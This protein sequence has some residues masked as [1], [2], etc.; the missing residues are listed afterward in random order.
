MQD[1]QQ[2]RNTVILG[3]GNSGK[4][5]L[6]EALLFTAGAI[7]RLGKVDDGNSNM[8]F[9]PE[10]TK[11]HITIGASFNHLG[12]KKHDIYITDTPGDDNFVNE[13]RFAAQ[14]ADT[15]ILTV[16]AVSGVRGQTERFV[17]LIQDNSLP[18]LICIT[19][20][21]K[22]RADFSKTV[23]GIRE[24]TG[25]NPVVLYLPIGAE[26]AF[27]GVVDI[28]AGKALLFK[29][30][31]SLEN[32][33]IPADLADEARSL[34]E[35]LM[36]YVAE[37]DDALIEK[38]LEEGELTKEELISGLKK[39]I[40][41]ASIAPVCA[42]ASLASKG[43]ATVLDTLVNFFPSPAEVP[44]RQGLNPK[45]QD[46][47]ERPGQADAP[48]SAQVFKLGFG[49]ETQFLGSNPSQERKENCVTGDRGPSFALFLV[50]MQ[51]LD[52]CGQLAERQPAHMLHSWSRL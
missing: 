10:E 32:T 31:G 23:A 36:E 21:D 44:A 43:A 50:G 35:T 17:D 1:V 27:K 30:D 52:E 34:R 47:V 6:A 38:F 7:K 46:S 26:D 15:A 3:H 14:V 16:G 5:T 37:T 11:R 8:D 41:N 28:A 4:T 42:C 40:K 19:K 20:M 2:I 51:L 49:G 12:W 9:E 24:N 22:E 29:D 13:S 48:F 25:L 33:D 18:C 45:N 39:A